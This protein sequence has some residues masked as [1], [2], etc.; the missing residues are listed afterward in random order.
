[1]P[2]E[3]NISKNARGHSVE[4]VWNIGG[5]DVSTTLWKDIKFVTLESSFAGELTKSEVRRYDKASKKY[6]K[7]ERPYVVSVHGRHMGGIDLIDSIMG[8]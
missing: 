1:M 8:S 4:N 7:S 6:I 5:I 2:T 3:K